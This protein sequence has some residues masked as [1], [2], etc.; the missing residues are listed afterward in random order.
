MAKRSLMFRGGMC[1]VP[2]LVLA[3]PLA[4]C[5]GG[6]PTP[7]PTPTPTAIVDTTPDAFAFAAVEQAGLSQAVDS[8]AVTI[9]GINAAANISVSGGQYSING[10]AF[11]ANAGTISSGDTVVVRLTTSANSLAQSQARLTVGGVSADFVV[12]TAFLTPA[13]AGDYFS[14]TVSDAN[15]AMFDCSGTAA[16]CTADLQAKLNAASTEDADGGVVRIAQG[17]YSLNQINMPSNVRLEITP[18]TTLVQL[19]RRLFS[20]GESRFLVGSPNATGPRIS[21]VEITTI[22]DTGSW[23]LDASARTQ[24]DTRP[25]VLSY[26][27]NFR[28]ANTHF[29]TNYFLFPTVMLVADND[30]NSP[31]PSPGQFNPTYDRIPENGVLENLTGNRIATGY[32]LAQAFSARNVLMRNFEA[33]NGIGVRLEGGSGQVGFPTGDS[34][35]LAGPNFGAITDVRLENIRVR[36]GYTAIY[37]KPHAKINKGNTILGATAIDSS[38]VVVIGTGDATDEDRQTFPD[39]TRGYFSGLVIAG[40]IGQTLTNPTAYLDQ[41][42]WWDTTFEG[43][44]FMPRPLREAGFTTFGSLPLDGSGQR[45]R[46][47]PAIPLIHL[48]RLSPDDLGNVS[49]NPPQYASQPDLTLAQLKNFQG[50]FYADLRHANFITNRTDFSVFNLAGSARPTAQFPVMYRGDAISGNGSIRPTDN[51]INR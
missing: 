30:S 25:M 17:T 15:P 47:S 48:A 26:V 45:R 12:T 37:L 4:S 38:F 16:A 31:N 40:D 13:N 39:Y 5:G 36:E 24:T 22:G 2:M 43:H 33:T 32:A 27:R 14:R 29:E 28:I 1:C 18:G 23:T 50:F 21:N 35:N 42:F 51:F 8:Q 19:E 11:T 46:A 44:F 34:L 41:D 20:F 9:R 6:S 3:L 10:G 49:I 7:S